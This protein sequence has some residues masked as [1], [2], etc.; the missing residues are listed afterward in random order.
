VTFGA[1][2]S[3]PAFSAPP[4]KTSLSAVLL[5]G[6]YPVDVDRNDRG[7]CQP[8]RR[9]YVDRGR[10]V[11]LV[12]LLALNKPRYSELIANVS[13]ECHLLLLV[14]RCS[15]PADKLCTLAPVISMRRL[16]KITKQHIADAS[17]NV[18]ALLGNRND[19]WLMMT[20]GYLA[21]WVVHDNIALEH[22]SCFSCQ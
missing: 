14:Q 11:V 4:C 15:S 18:E 6:G 7:H 19:R 5:T 22:Q 13:W 16:S 2:F 20:L 1:S 17:G 12:L 10:N 3:R 9:V 21:H 8:A